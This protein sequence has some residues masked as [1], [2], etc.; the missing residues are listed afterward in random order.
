M[1]R[2]FVGLVF[3][4][5]VL[6]TGS[7]AQQNPAAGGAVKE[8]RDP[9]FETRMA[10]LLDHNSRIPSLLGVK[11]S[12]GVK[13]EVV[14]FGD[15][16]TAGYGLSPEKAFPKLVDEYWKKNGINLNAV[17]AGVS[18]NTTAD[19]S[20]RME[21]SLNK[22]TLAAFVSIG[23]NDYFQRTPVLYVRGYYEKLI[24]GLQRAGIEVLIG[25]V[26]FPK[27]FPGYEEVYTSEFNAMTPYLA[28]KFN[29]RVLPSIHAPVFIH[30]AL[31]ADRRHPDQ[32]GHKL[33]AAYVLQFLHR[34]WIY[35]AEA[36]DVTGGKQI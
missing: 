3:C 21:K 15:S 10:Q 30:G 5:A 6:C 32:R 4:A 13:N 31:L 26:S 23:A 24:S 33:L 11:G 22:K 36:N 20:F 19:L 9:A 27:F 16:M 28:K 8:M 14:F 34:E 18:G 29:C 35:P 7:C 12:A 25:D 1:K 17:N 2:H